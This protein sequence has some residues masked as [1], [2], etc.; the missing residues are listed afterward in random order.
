[1]QSR[2]KNWCKTTFVLH[3]FILFQKKLIKN[4]TLIIYLINYVTLF[5]TL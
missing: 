2:F 5:N 3:I 1:M 4:V